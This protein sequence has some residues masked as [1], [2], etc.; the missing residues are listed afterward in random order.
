M[1]PFVAVEFEIKLGRAARAVHSCAISITSLLC[2]RLPPEHHQ[3]VSF[4][5]IDFSTTDPTSNLDSVHTV[6]RKRFP[7]SLPWL[8]TSLPSSLPTYLRVPTTHSNSFRLS[9]SG[10]HRRRISLG[11]PASDATASR[12]RMANSPC[13]GRGANQIASSCAYP[14]REASR[15]DVSTLAPT[16]LRFAT[17]PSLGRAP[18]GAVTP[19]WARQILR[20]TGRPRSIPRPRSPRS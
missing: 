19:F 13:E 12:N 6:H 16:L 20:G 3:H 1:L 7:L 15:V 18:P 14:N 11:L 9:L 17:L 8:S 2:L 5:A 10:R 4:S